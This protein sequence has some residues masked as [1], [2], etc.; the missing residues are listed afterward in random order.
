MIK[1][2]LINFKLMYIKSI[3]IFYIKI[4]NFILKLKMDS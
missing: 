1:I 4:V 3:Y 2:Y